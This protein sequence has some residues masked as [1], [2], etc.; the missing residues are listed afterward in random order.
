MQKGNGNDIRVCSSDC[1]RVSFTKYSIS[2]QD[3][4]MNST[5]IASLC[6]HFSKSSV[7]LNFT[8]S[9]IP[10][11][12]SCCLQ[13][14]VAQQR[15]VQ[16]I[17]EDMMS[18]LNTWDGN[19]ANKI[20]VGVISHTSTETLTLVGFDLTETSYFTMMNHGTIFETACKCFSSVET[21]TVGNTTAAWRSADLH[22]ALEDCP[23]R[24]IGLVVD[25]VVLK[26]MEE[27]NVALLSPCVAVVVKSVNE[28]G[29]EE[30]R[31]TV[32]NSFSL[33]IDSGS[34]NGCWPI[35][36]PVP[37]LKNLSGEGRKLAS[38]VHFC[39]YPN[40]TVFKGIAQN[41]SCLNNKHLGC[42]VDK[43][44]IYNLREDFTIKMRN[45]ESVK[46]NYTVS[47]VFLDSNL[48]DGSSDWNINDCKVINKTKNE[49]VCVCNHLTVFELLK[50]LRSPH[51]NK[52]EYLLGLSRN[53]STL[54]S[55]QVEALMSD[56]ESLVSGPSISLELASSSINTLSNLLDASPQTLASTSNRVMELVDEIAQRLVV[57]GKSATLLSPSLALAVKRVNYTNFQ[58]T[59]F[60]I[61]NSSSLQV[62]GGPT[63]GLTPQGSISLPASLLENLTDEQKQLVSRV[64]FCFYQSTSLFQSTVQNSELGGKRLIS[65]V[66]GCSVANLSLSSLRENVTITLK[67]DQANYAV[68]CA[69]WDARSN[70]GS[71]GWSTSGCSV[72]SRGDNGTV[73]SCSHLT[74]FGILLDLSDPSQQSNSIILTNFTYIGCGISS[75][76]LTV[77]VV[78]YLCFEKLRKDVPSKILI[79]LCL[80]LLLLN[81]LFLLDSL[82]ATQL[83]YIGLCIP[84]AFF[85]NYFLLAS[86]TWMTLQAV[87]MYL[88]I[89]KVFNNYVAHF[90]IKGSL[91]GWGI[92]LAVLSIALAVDSNIYGLVQNG[93]TENFCWWKNRVAYPIVVWT[94]FC[95]TF[96][97]N[98]SVFLAVLVLI[99]RIK[100]QRKGPHCVQKRTI[101][102]DLWSVSALAVLL[103]VG[104]VFALFAWD[105]VYLLFMYLFTICNSLQGFFIF[106]FRC[107][108]NE[109]VRRHWGSYLCCGQLKLR[110]IPG[111]IKGVNSSTPLVNSASRSA[112]WNSQG[113]SSQTAGQTITEELISHI[114]TSL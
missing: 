71:G 54:N 60:T 112:P 4:M 89:V 27:E 46:A 7:F 85:L 36:L 18:T 6:D 5:Q 31:F 47:C 97:L 17:R 28:S 59:V 92:P 20:R 106:V 30:T 107:A 81:L 33:Q 72:H 65:G 66:V 110:E 12:S 11:S 1:S 2:I 26:L 100:R 37:L 99:C 104:W 50:T 105:S 23:N 113:M 70:S 96:L 73:C 19:K 90:M 48:K 74:N 9:Y 103:G 109:N 29:S 87:H 3:H 77:T 44:K 84:T 41:N 108:A 25:A 93:A 21:S 88:T 35:P 64:S 78:T 13:H 56:I 8:V 58:E 98:F 57:E 76:F 111:M 91:I 67:Q 52:E 14:R 38:R 94:Y 53:A 83:D 34:S 49:V 10:T 79:Q 24:I 61:T 62:D 82:L 32:T 40:T 43:L 69:F 15:V 101:L 80:A 75:I 45:T 63:A 55:T 102:R 95:A 86:F 114:E 51:R 68:S 39:F 16:T 42:N 22:G